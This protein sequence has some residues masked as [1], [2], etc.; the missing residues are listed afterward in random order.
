MT[1]RNLTKTSL[2]ALAILLL[3]VAI[4]SYLNFGRHTSRKI[5]AVAEI[6]ILTIAIKEF[7]SDIGRYPTMDEGIKVL[8]EVTTNA[9]GSFGPF[10][11]HMRESDPWGHSFVY[12][13]PGV[14]SSKPF[15]IYSV[16]P[17]G[18][19]GGGDDIGNWSNDEE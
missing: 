4:A 13:F 19:E 5:A 2:A 1:N 18:K 14:R 10:I 11:P 3:T 9:N 17:D 16:G 6:Q 12:K 15:D 8:G 7:K